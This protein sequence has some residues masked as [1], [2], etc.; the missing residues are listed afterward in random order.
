M[1][2]RIEFDSSDSAELSPFE[3]LPNEILDQIFSHVNSSYDDETIWKAVMC[4]DYSMTG[5][6]KYYTQP[7]QS[8]PMRHL[9]LT[10]RTL[11]TAA[12]P[13]L[14]STIAEY[15]QTRDKSCHEHK[16]AT[17]L[18]MR[19]FCEN[20]NLLSHVRRVIYHPVA[21]MLWARYETPLAATCHVTSTEQDFGDFL[22][23]IMERLSTSLT[24]LAWNDC[25]VTAYP[26]PD[27]RDLVL[28]NIIQQS[29]STLSRLNLDL[30]RPVDGPSTILPPAPYHF[31]KAYN[32]KSF[33]QCEANNEGKYMNK[34]LRHLRL[35]LSPCQ[36]LDNILLAC[37]RITSLD[38]CLE[39]RFNFQSN[40]EDGDWEWDTW[41]Q[42]IKAAGNLSQSLTRLKL[43]AIRDR[44]PR[45]PSKEFP[46]PVHAETLVEFTSLKE[47]Y[48]HQSMLLGWD[49]Q[50]NALTTRRLTNIVP[51][52][53]ST[54]GLTCFQDAFFDVIH[55]CFEGVQTELKDLRKIE[56]HVDKT[57][58]PAT[59]PGFF[60]PNIARDRMNKMRARCSSFHS[61]VTGS[62]CSIPDR[63]AV[64]ISD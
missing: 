28:S 19:T 59:S 48:I 25:G 46:S 34:A 17:D 26:E 35:G 10:S 7:K 64:A 32:I 27:H 60:K 45:I 14:Y 13:F 47:L 37:P 16:R 21:E 56:L 42:A 51:K 55:R 54:L 8:W 49:S 58:T 33:D 61:E 41:I 20:A 53:V 57:C 43:D 9:C 29:E 31:V 24:M 50:R 4:S 2:E 36:S 3:R 52:Q 6:K 12:T 39:G 63:T 38:I 40:D 22:L 30:Q 44:F 11:N 15:P 5:N 1:P 18:L 23:T 62:L